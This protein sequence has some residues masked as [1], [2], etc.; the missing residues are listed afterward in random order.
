[1]CLCVISDARCHAGCPASFCSSCIQSALKLASTCPNCRQA[2]TPE[3][4]HPNKFV[5]SLIMQQKVRCKY[6]CGWHGALSDRL[7]HT[8]TACPANKLTS[9]KEC[10]QGLKVYEMPTHVCPEQEISCP[11]NCEVKRIKRK[12]LQPHLA[13]CPN[14][15]VSCPLVAQGCNFSGSL[16][17]NE[18]NEWTT[19]SRWEQ[20]RGLLWLRICRITW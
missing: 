16:R 2:M 5:D 6:E 1:V 12:M 19:D 15:I 11:Y 17:R 9:C 14:M 18:R 3:H 20:G 10:K 8:D 7:R 13:E 4:L